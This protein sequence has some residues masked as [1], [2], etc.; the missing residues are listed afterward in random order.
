MSIS[1]LWALAVIASRELHVV[2]VN[3]SMLRQAAKSSGKQGRGAELH[4]PALLAP[5]PM[6]LISSSF[7]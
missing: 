6:D 1:F 3:C 4:L 7:L 5:N 2:S